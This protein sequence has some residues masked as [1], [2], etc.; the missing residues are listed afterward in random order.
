MVDDYL[1]RGAAGAQ[2]A[3]SLVWGSGRDRVSAEKSPK[4]TGCLQDS[5]CVWRT[6][7][8]RV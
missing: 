7:T 2:E 1:L 6:G 4:E 5:S 8:W 3:V